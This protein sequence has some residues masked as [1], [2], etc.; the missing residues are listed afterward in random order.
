[1]PMSSRRFSKCAL[2]L[3]LGFLGLSVCWPAGQATAQSARRG[4][5]SGTQSE[6]RVLEFRADLPWAMLRL[7]GENKIS[8]VSP[9]RVPGPLA[10]ELWLSA[11]GRG[12]EGQLGRVTVRLDE[13]GPR[14]ESFGGVP[15]RER[16]MRSFLYPGYPQW[17]Y[18]RRGRAVLMGGAAL[19]G[20]IKTYMYQQDLQDAGDATDAADLAHSANTLAEEQPRLLNELEAAREDEEHAVYRRN[21]ALAA[22]GACWGIGLLDML[23]FSPRFRVSHADEGSLALHMQRKTRMDAVLRSALFPGLGQEYNG[24]RKKAFLVGLGGILAGGYLLDQQTRYDEAVRAFEKVESRYERSTSVDERYTLG[25]ELQRLYDEEEDRY[26]RRNVALGV[27]GGYWV[28]SLLDAA[29]SF[30]E[31]WGDVG[32]QGG[33]RFGLVVEPGRGELA[34]QVCF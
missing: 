4:F 3:G 5:G 14:I 27:A 30:S 18:G 2:L 20:L 34:A 17:R 15:F 29:V 26:R 9:L 1:M 19:A 6:G 12:V 25:T 13:Q 8:G 21:L 22:T 7:E 31:P 33:R 32:V 24:Q 28:L 11:K 10:G 16:L 23:L